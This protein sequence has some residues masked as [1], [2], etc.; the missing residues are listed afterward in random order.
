MT[1]QLI[2]LLCLLATL[3][4]GTAQAEQA[5]DFGNYL[6]HYSAVATGL[7]DP[8]TARA[9][10][11]LRSKQRGLVNIAVQRKDAAR[12]PVAARV[13]VTIT[14]HGQRLQELPVREVREQAAIYYLAG[15][16]YRSGQTLNFDVSIAPAGQDN[17]FIFSF[18][19]QFFAD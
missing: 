17:T 14:E 18:S 11:I 5:R 2:T 7:L 8:A 13:R 19:G 9:Y 3:A 10:G 12:T 16:D 15:F 6:V 4:P 1:R